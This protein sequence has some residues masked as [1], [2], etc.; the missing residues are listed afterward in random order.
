VTLTSAIHA[1]IVLA[2]ALSLRLLDLA[3]GAELIGIGL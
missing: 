2:A 1:K 3:I